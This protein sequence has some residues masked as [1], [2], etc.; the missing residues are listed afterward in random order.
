MGVTVAP[1]HGDGHGGAAETRHAGAA[2]AINNA[3]SRAA[4]LLAVAALGV[5]FVARLARSL[6][7]ALAS[8]PLS[9]SALDVVREQRGRLA[10]A[11][12]RGL[13]DATRA[14]V[15][16]AFDDAFVSAFRFTMIVCAVL[17]ALSAGVG[18]FIDRESSP[19]DPGLR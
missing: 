11:D 15:R 14:A 7:G 3:D 12:L 5:T 9:S 6:D 1:A 13:D 8:I 17:A 19:D 2:S 18:M 16:S 4:G 10:G